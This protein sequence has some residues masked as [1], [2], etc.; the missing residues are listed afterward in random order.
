MRRIKWDEGSAEAAARR[1]RWIAPGRAKVTHPEYGSVVVPCGSKLG[2]LMCAAEYW[3]C[4]WSEITD[5]DV[6]AAA[7]GD[8]RAVCPRD[9][10]AE[11]IA[12]LGKKKSVGPVERADAGE[13][14]QEGGLSEA[15]IHGS[16][17]KHKNELL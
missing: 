13:S 11:A 7:P 8:G 10:A 9:Y 15:I 16:G 3:R 2:A 6:R 1:N 4:Q 5:A 17:E 12:A 14:S